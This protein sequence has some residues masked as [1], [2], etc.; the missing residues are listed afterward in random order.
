VALSVGERGFEPPASLLVVIVLDLMTVRAQDDTLANLVEYRLSGKTTAD[1]VGHVEFFLLLARVVE[2]QGSIVREATSRTLEGFLVL[3][4]PL[5]Q[6][7][8]T[9]VRFD[10]LTAP[11]S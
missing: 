9:F 10:P 1:H 5:S 8:A 6:G 3:V 4:Q 11:T 7:G 2:L